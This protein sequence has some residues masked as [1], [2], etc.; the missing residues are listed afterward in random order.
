MLAV[1]Q[2]WNAW[3]DCAY[4]GGLVRDLLGGNLPGFE[5]AQFFEAVEE[6]VHFDCRVGNGYTDELWQGD[7]L[8]YFFGHHIRIFGWIRWILQSCLCHTLLQ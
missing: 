5:Q 6:T 4:T 7:H 8:D 1:L 3:L 2:P